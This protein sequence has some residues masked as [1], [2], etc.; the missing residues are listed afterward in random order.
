M[1][2]VAGSACRASIQAVMYVYAIIANSPH[3]RKGIYIYNRIVLSCLA[4]KIRP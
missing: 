4:L 2:N 3:T 1:D